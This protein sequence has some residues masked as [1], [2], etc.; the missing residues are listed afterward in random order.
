M[1]NGWAPSTLDAPIGAWG[2]DTLQR[3]GVAHRGI[4]SNT[5]AEYSVI[6]GTIDSANQPLSGDR[7][8]T[9]RVEKKDF[10]KVA[11]YWGITIYGLPDRLLRPNAA[12]RWAV[13]IGIDKGVKFNADGS[14]DIYVQK[15]PPGKDKE[16]NWLPAPDG[17]FQLIFRMY[18]P[19]DPAIYFGDYAPPA[20]N[21][22]N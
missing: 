7:R 3:A 9:I 1:V 12:N 20:I 11:A 17:P 21:R 16:A 19:T 8:Y 5:A 4:F 14:L 18:S 2:A 13:N 15:E 10:P 6:A 22:V